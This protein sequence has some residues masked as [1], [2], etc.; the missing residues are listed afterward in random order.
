MHLHKPVL[1]IMAQMH[2]SQKLN[3]LKILQEKKSLASPGTGKGHECCRSIFPLP[4]CVEDLHPGLSLL[5][6][7]HL[8]SIFQPGAEKTLQ[9]IEAVSRFFAEAERLAIPQTGQQHLRRDATERRV[10]ACLGLQQGEDQQQANARSEGRL[11]RLLKQ[12]LSFEQG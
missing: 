8:D 11:L 7:Q 3:L 12:T 10:A 4:M 1:D 6:V 9:A 5:V 2:C